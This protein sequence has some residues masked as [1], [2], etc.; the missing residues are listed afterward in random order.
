MLD[1]SHFTSKQRQAVQH[2]D[3]NLQ[4]IACAGA[5]KT[6]VVACRVAYLLDPKGPHR[7]SPENV[8]AFTF[9]D[10]A[11]A[12]LKQ[13]IVD[14]TREHLGAVLGMAATYVGTIH[15]FCLNLLTDEVP[16]F[17][18]Y[19]VLTE[20]Q[21]RIFVDRFSRLSGLTASTRTD[22]T[23]LKRYAN[24]PV[25]VSALNILRE[26]DVDPNALAGVS[27]ADGLKAYE[28]LLA[29]HAYFDYTSMMVE[30]VR[31][32]EE[33][34]ALRA[35]VASRVRYVIVDE[36]QDVNPIQERLIA[37]LHGLGA[38]LCVIGDDDQT[39]HQWRGS[40][41]RNIIDFESRYAP[42]TQIRLEENFRSS[43][44]VVEVGREFIEQNAERL[45]K[46]MKPASAQPYERG[47]IT[48]M[49]FPDPGAEAEF[50]VEQIRA[51]RGVSFLDGDS[52]RGLAYSDMA[53]LLRSVRNNAEPLVAALRVAE[54]PFV[55]SGMNNLFDTPE[56]QAARALFTWMGGPS[57]YR[58]AVTRADVRAAWENAALGLSGARLDAAL[59]SVEEALSAFGAPEAN[60]WSV[61]GIQRVFVTFLEDAGLVEEKVPGGR[62]EVALANLGKFSQLISDFESIHFRSQPA[63]K[64]PTFAEFLHFQAPNLYDEGWL[65]NQ[66]AQ[67]DAVRIMTVHQAKGMQWP[68]VFMPALL[69]NRFPSKGGG[70][71]SVWHL[72][73]PDAVSGAARYKGN[74]E[75]ERR[76]FYVAVTRAQK[77]LFMTWAPIDGNRLYKKASEFYENV[78]ASPRIRRRLPDFS[79]R[80][81]L[82]PT[83]RRSVADVSLSFS[84]LKY[85][86]ECP[87]QFKLRILFGFNAPLHEALGYGKSL[88]DVL[89]EVHGAASRG[90]VPSPAEIPELLRR[91]LHLPYAYPALRDQLERSAG[92]VLAKYFKDNAALFPNVEFSEKQIEIALGDGVTVSGRIDLV[93][94]L[95]TDETTIVDLKTSERSQDEEVTELQLHIYVLGLQELT[96]RTADLVEIYELDEGKRKRRA[97]DDEFVADVVA[98]VQRAAATLRSGALDPTPGRKVCGACDYR[99]MCSH[100]VI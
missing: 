42:V 78:L 9:A 2:G 99:R 23:P 6:E 50:V 11:A 51:L 73:P 56:A 98:G 58:P 76:L 63:E 59:Q 69:R 13:R 10:K 36:Y 1:L 72:V 22:G 70:G 29:E 19:R 54:V 27:V 20:V 52:K 89:A 48:A 64:Y 35:R 61:Y 38:T 87:Y 65:D 66:Y 34:D 68:V 95:D 16:D 85:F 84:E 17:L 8:V 77:F 15:G 47:D 67:P 40:D 30:A 53:I 90:E 44:G 18:K 26:S 41:V 7:L 55:I 62:G 83:P 12:E 46:A 25:Y 71:L 3:G 88:H 14:R 97:V 94:R 60:A 91:H 100:A 32:L 93:R 4:L 92:K 81:R 45:P 5:G 82:V 49:A 75:D 28:S 86:F 37:A 74:I 24:T 96:G 31:A 33:N 80:Q 79:S 21:Q 39:I 57:R 43:E